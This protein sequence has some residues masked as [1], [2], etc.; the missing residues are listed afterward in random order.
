MYWHGWHDLLH[1][2]GY[3]FY[4]WTSFGVTFAAMIIEIWMLHLRKKTKI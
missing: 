4:V 3:A 2:G 1:M